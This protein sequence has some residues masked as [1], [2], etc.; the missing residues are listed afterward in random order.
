MCLFFDPFASDVQ[1]R[2]ASRPLTFLFRNTSGH[3]SQDKKS[4]SFFLRAPYILRTTYFSGDD[5][6]RR[7]QGLKPHLSEK[8]KMACRSIIHDARGLAVGVLT[9]IPLRLSLGWPGSM[10]SVHPKDDVRPS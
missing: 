1:G 5:G 2:Y 7:H 8:V 4:F 3:T 10:G 9:P 6:G